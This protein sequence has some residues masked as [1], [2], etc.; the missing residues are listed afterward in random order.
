MDSRNSFFARY[1]SLL[2][3]LPLISLPASQALKQRDFER[4]PTPALYGVHSPN[5]A[6][7]RRRFFLA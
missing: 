7:E 1:A 6:K 4:Q 3:H 5:Q 2:T